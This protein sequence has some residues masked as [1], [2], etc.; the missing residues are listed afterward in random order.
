M[1]MTSAPPATPEFKAMKPALRPM[2][3]TTITRPWA[4]AVGWSLSMASVAVETAVSK[5]N[6]TEVCSMS[7]SMVLGTPTTGMPFPERRRAMLSVPSPP[8]AMRASKP[9]SLKLPHHLGRAVR[10]GGV[11]PG[12]RAPLHP[13]RARA[14]GGPEDGAAEV[15]DSAHVAGVK[16][17]GSLGEQALEPVLDAED[18]PAEGESR[19]GGRANDRV[20]AGTVAASGEDGE[21]ERFLGSRGLGS[22]GF[23]LSWRG[24]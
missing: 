24:G 10:V 1:R 4:W 9:I 21:A 12:V 17:M 14:V 18:F 22:H 7:L 15:E 3:S 23:R 19:A 5:P 13:K 16:L 2:S 6:V 8:M 20:Q 11:R